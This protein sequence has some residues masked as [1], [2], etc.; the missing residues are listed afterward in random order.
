MCQVGEVVT[1]AIRGGLR[2]RKAR[3]LLLAVDVTKDVVWPEEELQVVYR[4]RED[5][6]AMLYSYVPRAMLYIYIG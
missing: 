1:W 5:S 2:W 6:I 3:G 4:I